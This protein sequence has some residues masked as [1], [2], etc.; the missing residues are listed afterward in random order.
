MALRA[1]SLVCFDPG[2]FLLG[3]ASETQSDVGHLQNC[4]SVIE[5][6]ASQEE[7]AGVGPLATSLTVGVSVPPHVVLAHWGHGTVGPETVNDGRYPAL[8]LA[9]PRSFGFT[10]I[11]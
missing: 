9:P 10:S 3:S 6:G 1:R 4:P 2:G 11:Q 7:V 8:F 5:F